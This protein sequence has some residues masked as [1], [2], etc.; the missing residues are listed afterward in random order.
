MTKMRRMTKNEHKEVRNTG[1]CE[2]YNRKRG[3]P[4]MHLKVLECSFKVSF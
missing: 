3:E 2:D 4:D 1:I